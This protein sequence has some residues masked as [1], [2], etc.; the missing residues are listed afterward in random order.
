MEASNPP[1]PATSDWADR[2]TASLQN[3]SVRVRDFLAAQQ[4]RLEQAE[5]DL[6]EQLRII[7]DQLG[8]DRAHTMATKEEILRRSEELARQME[9]LSVLRNEFDAKQAQWEQVQQQA[10]RHQ[11]A[12]LDQVHQ[13][14]S[15]L[16]RG[17][18]DLAR[19]NSEADE[20]ENKYHQQ[21]RTLE[22]SQNEVNAELQQLAELRN[23]L[24]VKQIELESQAQRVA[25]QE[26]EARDNEALSEQIR[27]Q[28]QDI[29]GCY[30]EIT[31]RE[32]KIEAAEANNHRELRALEIAR[33]ECA[34][35]R[36]QIST[37][38]KRLEA[39]QSELETQAEHLARRESEV[40]RNEA[41][42]EQ[43]RQQREE[44]N[45]RNEEL[46]RRESEA[47]TAEAKYRQQQRMLDLIQSECAAEREQISTIRKRLE[48][49]LAELD[50][51][52]VQPSERKTDSTREFAIAGEMRKKQ[53]EISGQ[54]EE[55]AFRQ[56]EV[57][58][59]EVKNRQL[60]RALELAQ[61]ECSSEREQIT[62]VRK[63]LEVKQAELDTHADQLTAREAE[64]KRNEALAE[65]I[66]GQQAE[67]N[68]RAQELG[69][70]EIKLHTTEAEL[71]RQQ[72]E[73]ELAQSECE[74][75]REQNT[76]IRKR[77]EAKQAELET[78]A[79]QLAAREA[80]AKRNEVLAE[81]ISGQ[82]AESNRR[83]Q[84]LGEREI[85]LH[86]A[87]AELRRQQRELELAQS[88]CAADREQIAAVRKRQETRQAELE[89]DAERLARRD[90]ETEE[91][92]RRIAQAFKEQRAARL[93]PTAALPQAAAI[94]ES[95]A[96]DLR[97]R[98]EMA[99][100]DLRE[101]KARNADLQEQLAKPLLGTPQPSPGQAGVL[102]WEVEKQRILA[103][104]ETDFDAN[105]PRQRSQRLEI[106]EVVRTT[107]QIIAEKE[108]EI[109]ELK[110]LLQTQSSNLG[111]M[112]LGAAAVGEVFEKDAAIREEREN[113]QRLQDEYKVKLR[114]AEIE[115]SVERAKI[116][117]QRAE[118]EEKLRQLE[119]QAMR[120]SEKPGEQ[121]KSGAPVR[122][123]WLARLGLKEQDEQKN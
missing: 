118:V 112:A 52:H 114:Q 16:D 5:T 29:E 83:A 103:A 19:R 41:L 79:N 47:E 110:Q 78:H 86:A 84:E 96:E 25:R 42:A 95:A 43:I 56:L 39:K 81:Q 117:R 98:Y 90:A 18:Q 3:Q 51:S 122:G 36:E 14:Q 31:A 105:D 101:L 20:A 55:L 80:E 17:F 74:A 21:K 38:R 15:D 34:A 59:A 85:K 91:Q 71:R 62:A 73:L 89:N 123:R 92:R 67:I 75:E 22:L 27:Q 70:R 121:T 8:E 65:Q 107:G 69:E 28:Q 33:G 48:A 94:D 64:A 45:R 102:N 6:S 7:A 12:L 46:A 37:I 50:F 10:S 77:L 88:E 23:R 44:I 111:S 120:A 113:L 63:R 109:K 58:A 40:K 115:I 100:E 11:Q 119:S 26:A 2:F 32:I 60:Q 116:A 87:E 66:S 35:E 108:R 53:E 24:E 104:L 82:Q 54:L 13:Q 99:L 97:R 30:A 68:R 76:A 72:R 93:S 61:D 9:T 1:A 4:Q 106:E 49:R 57:D